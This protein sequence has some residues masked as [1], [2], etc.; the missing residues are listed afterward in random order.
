MESPPSRRRGLK[1]FHKLELGFVSNVAS[2]AEAW[3]E[4]Y[5]LPLHPHWNLVASFAEAWIEK[6]NIIKICK[7]PELVASFAE[8]WIEN[9]NPFCLITH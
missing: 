5:F 1:T 2:F 8:A 4:N 6:T 7:F 9:D 3:I